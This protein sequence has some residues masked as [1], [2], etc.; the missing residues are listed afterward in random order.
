LTR[1]ILVPEAL[2]RPTTAELERT[3]GKDMAQRL[4]L[5]VLARAWQ[6]LLKGLGEVR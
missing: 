4:S 6:M 1:A 2:D 3:R 5:P